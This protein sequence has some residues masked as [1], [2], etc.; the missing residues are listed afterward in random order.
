MRGYLMFKEI[1]SQLN[2]DDLENEVLKFWEENDIFKKSIKKD[3]EPFIF[4]EGPPTANGKPGIHHV[5]ARTIKDIVTRYKSL[6]GYRVD[7]KA[8]WDTHGLPVEI[9]VEKQLGLEGRE[10]VL[11]YGLEKFNKECK[12]SVFTY[13]DLWDNMTK[14]M[15]YWVDLEHPYVTCENNYI[16]SVWWILNQLFKKGLVYQGYKIQPYCPKCGT[17]LSSHEVSQGYKDVKDLTATVRFPIV[18]Q[19]NTFFLAWTT[20]PWTLPSNM[21]LSVGPEIT[22]VKIKHNDSKNG[23]EY[24]ILAKDLLSAVVSGDYEIVDEFLGKTLEGIAYKPLYNFVKSNENSHKVLL[25]DYVTTTDGTGIV[26]SAPAYGEDD[27]QICKKNNIPV[28]IIVGHDGKFTEQAGEFAD[29]DIKE[30]DPEIVT[31]LKKRGLLFKSQKME[32]S[33]PHCWRHGTPLFYYATDSWFISTTK[34]KEKFLNN[35]NKINWHPKEVGEGRFGKWLENNIDWSLSRRRYWGTPLNIWLS[36][37]GSEMK[38]IGSVAELYEEME[39]S[40]EAGFMTEIPKDIDL[41][42]PYIDNVFLVDSKGKKMTRTP[43]V[44]DVWFDSGSMPLAQW[45]YPFENKKMVEEQL[46]Q[47]DFICEGIDQ[48]RGW[49]YTLLAISTMLFD[50]PAYKNVVVNN[51][52]LDKEG[53]KMSKSKG[54][55][56][57][58]FK[59]IETYGIDTLRWFFVA[60]SQPWISKRFDEEV[61]KE[62]Q[63]KFIGTLV[64]TYSFFALYA[65]VDN[66][67]RE[68]AQIP[69]EERSEIDQWILSA[70]YTTIGEFQKLMDNYD[71]TG[72]TRLLSN[73]LINDVSNWYV[74]RNRRRFWKGEKGKDKTT[75]YQTLYEVLR[76]VVIMASPI[77]PFLSDYIYRNLK[78]ENEPESIHHL[79]FSELNEENKKHINK[80]VEQKMTTAQQIVELGRAIRSENNLKV[81]LPLA[82]IKVFVESDESKQAVRE[83]QDIILE[84]LNIKSLEIAEQAD[85]LI[86]RKAKPNFKALGPAFGK[87]KIVN[88]VAERIR[89]FSSDEFT[90][91]ENGKELQVNVEEHEISLTKEFYEVVHEK[92]EGLAVDTF[93]GIT[94]AIDI[95]ITDELKEEGVRREFINRL[96]NV[97]KE[98]GFEVTDRI[99]VKVD[100]NEKMS[101]IL[102]KNSDH[103]KSETLAN[104]FTFEKVKNETNLVSV[105]GEN[106][107]LTVKKV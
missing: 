45:H 5:M 7:R 58:P 49:F 61:V 82:S 15:G 32:H 80:S 22:Y 78:K 8:G 25:G 30:S 89:N 46:R 39:K 72:A 107:K 102:E 90:I 26:H 103:I 100:T 81:R 88:Q 29:L 91:L 33:Y 47:A 92:K 66:F 77:M 69:F 97:R 16:E 62:V 70:L 48:T 83:L 53:K 40:V 36:E 99:S 20:T 105:E 44:I 57:D 73:F 42:K 79:T 74:R 71:I 34:F 96:Q 52:I 18:D 51:L 104:S 37:D 87:L 38:S 75:A 9:E 98:L 13:K 17:A 24:L 54:N 28:E 65:N 14:R 35:N 21:S 59:A 86:I 85:E 1:P 27:Y 84:E 106:I 10:Q 93:E 19:E 101:S 12:S 68:E 2:Y 64:N 4:F 55:T 6:R 3:G 76:N 56:V 95:V 41:H 63:R 60:S 94:V 50:E 43:E 23:E 31:D 67:D 11:D